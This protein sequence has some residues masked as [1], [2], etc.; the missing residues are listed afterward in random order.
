VVVVGVFPAAFL[1][2]LPAALASEP[3]PPLPH[4]AINEMPNRRS[5]TLA[6]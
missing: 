3:P 2:E 6:A 4:A 5:P 1:L